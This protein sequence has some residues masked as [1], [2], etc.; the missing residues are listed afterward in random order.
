MLPRDTSS[1]D[2]LDIGA[3]DGRTY[4]YFKHRAFKSY[5]AFDLSPAMLAQCRASNVI[6]IVGDMNERRPLLDTSYDVLIS[7]FTLEYVTDLQDFFAEAYRVMRQDGIF[8]FSYFHQRREFVFGH[9]ETQYKIEQ[10]VHSYD[11]IREALEYNFFTVEE[12]A[13]RDGA[14]IV[15]YVYGCR[16]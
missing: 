4:E 9:A 11:H 15:G 6:K 8:I 13:L 3:G 5:T 12:I 14:K 7:F 1:C 2:I 16:Q 10:S